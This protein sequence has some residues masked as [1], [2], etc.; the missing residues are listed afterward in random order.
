MDGHSS[1]G[2]PEGFDDFYVAEFAALARFLIRNGATV[3]E[4]AD[5]AQEAF[6]EA[7]GRWHSIKN[8]RAWMRKV[9]YRV[10]L[11]CVR[12][13]ELSVEE[14]PET[15]GPLSPDVIVGLDEETQFVVDVFAELPY[16]QRRVMSYHYDG[17]SHS[18]IAAE[19]SM[20]PDAVRQ[21]LCRGRQ[22]L[23][24]LLKE[25]GNK[26]KGTDDV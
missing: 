18:E 23:I 10:F 16:A 7:Y 4:A 25:Y 1:G 2:G 17:F 6:V 9:A 26:K 20:S 11:R 12:V 24:E 3:H 13:K 19:L 21:N 5:A 15:A 8:P 14:P 22:R